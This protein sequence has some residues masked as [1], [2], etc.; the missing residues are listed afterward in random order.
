MPLAV[1]C[2]TSSQLFERKRLKDIP[3]RQLRSKSAYAQILPALGV[4]ERKEKKSARVT[5][6][7][8]AGRDVGKALV[9]EERSLPVTFFP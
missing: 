5:V 1:Q 8:T 6:Q 7:L 2:A 4:L 3:N 9:L